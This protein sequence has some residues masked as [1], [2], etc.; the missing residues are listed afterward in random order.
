MQF[1]IEF[2]LKWHLVIM[3]F[4]ANKNPNEILIAFFTSIFSYFLCICCHIS[5]SIF[6]LSF[7]FSFSFSLLLALWFHLFSSKNL[8]SSVHFRWLLPSLY[9]RHVLFQL[10]VESIQ[11]AR[12]QK[13][14]TTNYSIRWQK[15]A[16]YS[17]AHFRLFMHYSI[18]I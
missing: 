9:Y 15:H 17:S 12:W 10:V 13:K 2:I 11:D 7:G 6:F 14:I 4:D 8:L 18:L 16:E 5:H 3:W 1:A